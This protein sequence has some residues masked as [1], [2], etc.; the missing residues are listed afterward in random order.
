M[1]NR[2]GAATAALF[3][4]ALIVSG[5]GSTGPRRGEAR[6]VAV[7]VTERGFEPR[8]VTVHRGD[9]VTLVITR[10]IEQTCAVRVVVG[11]RAIEKDLPLHEPVRVAL[12]KVDQDRIS[13]ACPM[14][15][16]TGEV[17]AR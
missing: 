2:W 12:G 1:R 15:M 4:A 10:E 7:K 5:C 6:E 8:E 16:I 9:D 17:V 13:Y 11:D 14:R 3:T